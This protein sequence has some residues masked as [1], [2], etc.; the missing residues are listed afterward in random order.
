[1]LGS[2][3][4]RRIRR[5]CEPTGRREALP[6][7]RLREAIQN[8][9]ADW[10]ASSQELFAMTEVGQPALNHEKAIIGQGFQLE[11]D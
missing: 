5:H 9:E 8:L 7:D 6:D 10:I 11:Y 3:V 2:A 4:S 1:M